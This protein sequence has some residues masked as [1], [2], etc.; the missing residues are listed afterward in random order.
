VDA[1][2]IDVL[3]GR[4]LNGMSL[5]ETEPEEQRVLSIIDN[6]KRLFDTRRDS[7]AHLPDYG[8]PDITQVYR[9]LPYSIEGLRQ[10]VKDAV[11]KFE[12]RLRRVRVEHQKG[13]PYGMRIIFILTA[14]LFNG[15]RVQFQT[16]FTS[17][18]LTHV[19]QWLRQT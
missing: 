10:A 8:L 14:E 15:R 12:P 4:F 5:E 17:S 19:S 9:D 2:L 1:G 16:T 3:N 18:D 7:I 6:L 11:E 13:D